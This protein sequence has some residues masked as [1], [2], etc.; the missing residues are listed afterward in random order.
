MKPLEEQ[1]SI[2][3][4]DRFQECHLFYDATLELHFVL[5]LSLLKFNSNMIFQIG[6][7]CRIYPLNNTEGEERTRDGIN[8]C[9]LY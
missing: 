4:N 9:E 1:N 7:S 2:D 6:Y 8:S 5:I 3:V